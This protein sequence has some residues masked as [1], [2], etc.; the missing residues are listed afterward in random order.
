MSDI[1]TFHVF[2]YIYLVLHGFLCV[3]IET[4]LQINGADR[5][6]HD[7]VLFWPP[8]GKSYPTGSSEF[9]DV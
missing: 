6:D 7:C 1:C 8:G 2:I 5:T 9:F 3:L 4:D